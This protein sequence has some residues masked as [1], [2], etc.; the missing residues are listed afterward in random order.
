MACIGL[1]WQAVYGD[2]P[3]LTETCKPRS[4]R[5]IHS[6]CL[7]IILHRVT[8]K[9]VSSNVARREFA[10]FFTNFLYKTELFLVQVEPWSLMIFI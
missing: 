9:R 6:L 5:V 4:H 3:M 2:E 10:V 1:R 7:S 8:V